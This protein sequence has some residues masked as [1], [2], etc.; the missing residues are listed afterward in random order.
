MVETTTATLIAAAIAAAASI[1]T[2]VLRLSSDRSAEARRAYREGLGPVIQELG[3][4]LHMTVACSVLSIRDQ[5]TSNRDYWESRKAHA[6]AALRKLRPQLRYQLWGMDDGLKA[7]I[8]LPDWVTTNNERDYDHLLNAATDL[9]RAL[10][11]SI[12]RCYH[13]GRPPSLVE[14]LVI[15]YRVQKLRGVWEGL[16]GALERED[17]AGGM[18]SSAVARHDKIYATIVER[19]DDVL[20]AKTDRGE[21]Y[22][23]DVGNR[24]GKGSRSLAQPGV[25]IKLYQREGEEFW[26]YRFVGG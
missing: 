13:G 9:R 17:L 3:N 2:L 23:V 18:V 5:E 7:M 14:R 19:A 22:R 25:R 15:S 4:A 24:S 21:I 11:E 6:R 20:V 10:D 8:C 26:R 1:I 12:R 16:S